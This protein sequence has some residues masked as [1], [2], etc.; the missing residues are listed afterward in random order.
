MQRHRETLLPSS[1]WPLF[2]S[3]DARR[4]LTSLRHPRCKA[5]VRGCGTL[6]RVYQCLRL[7]LEPRRRAQSA[8]AWC[9]QSRDVGWVFPQ[10]ETREATPTEVRDQPA[11][12]RRRRSRDVPVETARWCRWTLRNRGWRVL[13]S[14]TRRMARAW[15]GSWWVVTAGGNCRE[16]SWWP[17]N[18]ERVEGSVV[19]R[20]NRRR[21]GHC[22][23]V[24][25]WQLSRVNC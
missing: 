15:F 23:S 13:N 24:C 1:E 4:V 25:A 22:E 10:P 16:R 19:G 17:G 18:G 12:P 11:R 9:P 5:G 6:G 3:R 21:A 7:R 14:C 2:S 8:A 20:G